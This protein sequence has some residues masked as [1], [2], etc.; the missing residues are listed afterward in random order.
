[1][2]ETTLQIIIQSGAIGINLALLLIFYKIA[3][4]FNATM[5][6]VISKVDDLAKALTSLSDKIE[7]CP[8]NKF[9]V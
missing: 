7:G 1:M 4:L 8:H 5:M 6:M 2:N 3:V 9:N